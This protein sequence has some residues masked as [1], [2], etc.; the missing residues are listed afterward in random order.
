MC[1]DCAEKSKKRGL[2]NG[3]FGPGG[4]YGLLILRMVVLWAME[5]LTELY[6]DLEDEL[7]EVLNQPEPPETEEEVPAP[8]P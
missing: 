5:F 8:T 1:D 4:A 3:S 7:D 2:G 6:E